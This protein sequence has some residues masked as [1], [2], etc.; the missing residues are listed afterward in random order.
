LESILLADIRD[1][2]RTSLIVACGLAV[3]ASCGSPPPQ[4]EGGGGFPVDVPG[5]RQ[6]AL[7]PKAVLDSEGNVVVLSNSV[8]VVQGALP[9]DVSAGS[10]WTDLFSDPRRDQFHVWESYSASRARTLQVRLKRMGNVEAMQEEVSYERSEK[11]GYSNMSKRAKVVAGAAQ[12]VEGVGGDCL[13]YS[14][15][16]YSGQPMR[17]DRSRRYRVAGVSLF[18]GVRNVTISIQWQGMDYST[19]WDTQ[20][21]KGLDYEISKKQAIAV[22]RPI[23]ASLYPK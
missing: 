3:L 4:E 13:S 18:C 23:V 1:V 2:A 22:M 21:G 9:V 7:P 6:A 11:A 19:P 10:P 17:G 14:L 20:R 12:S 8:K 15:D 16:L 5:A